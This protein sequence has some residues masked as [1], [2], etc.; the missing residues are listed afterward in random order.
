MASSGLR[1]VTPETNR[2]CRYD[3]DFAARKVAYYGS[4]G[5]EHLEAYP[6]VKVD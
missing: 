4:D 2:R 3:V 5:E 1:V 6:A